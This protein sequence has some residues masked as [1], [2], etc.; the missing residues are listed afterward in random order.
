MVKATQGQNSAHLDMARERSGSKPT[1]MLPARKMGVPLMDELLEEVMDEQ[2]SMACTLSK[3][4]SGD[5]PDAVASDDRLCR[6]SQMGASEDTEDS[7]LLSGDS[8]LPSSLARESHGTATSHEGARSWL[9]W[10]AKKQTG[11]VQLG[12]SRHSSVRYLLGCSQASNTPCAYWH[13]SPRLHAPLRQSGH[14]V[15][16]YAKTRGSRLRAFSPVPDA[17]RRYQAD[18]NLVKRCRLAAEHNIALLRFLP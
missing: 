12:R 11:R 8:G 14:G 16:R 5:W 1:P 18:A 9:M 6:H 7:S 17:T 3:A 13:A 15:P 2:G 10:C 4:D